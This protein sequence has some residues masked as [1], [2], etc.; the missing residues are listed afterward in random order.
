MNKIHPSSL[1]HSAAVLGDDIEIGP[2]CT[3]GPEVQLGD[4]CRLISHVVIDGPETVIGKNNTFYPFCVVGSD[5]QDQKYHQERTR[6]VVGESNI[7]REWVSVNRGTEGGGG[8][9]RI[10]DENQFMAYVHV[11]HDCV[12]GNHNTLASYVGLSGH[13]VIDDYVTLGG[14]V[15]V[16]QFLRI[17]SYAYIG[18]GSVVDKNVPP[19][20]IGYGNRLEIKG[21]NIVG[22]KRSGFS[23]EAIHAIADTHQLYFR[24]DLSEAEALRR[25]E[26][27]S[28]EF[29][30]VRIFTEFLEAVGGKVH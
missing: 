16:V 27:K 19:Y 11:A 24:S 2:F 1:V 28:G 21:A 10:G 12:L 18:G 22:L 9:T 17:G 25:I 23:R 7:F 6:L 5:P 3:V 20:T 26:E 15:G 13:V 30:E 29:D 8:E 4:G 14:R